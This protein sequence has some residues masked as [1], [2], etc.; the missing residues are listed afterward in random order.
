MTGGCFSELSK[1]MGVKYKSQG[2][3][4]PIASKYTRILYMLDIN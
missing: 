3:T 2:E 1:E 4:I